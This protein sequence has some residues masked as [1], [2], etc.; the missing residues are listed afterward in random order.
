MIATLT[1]MGGV[2]VQAQVTPPTM[3]AVIYPQT[4]R[5]DVSSDY[6][7]VMVKDPYRW[8]ETDWRASNEVKDWIVAQNRISRTYLE[9]IPQRELIRKRLDD[10][11]D[12]EQV[13]TPRVINGRQFYMR[14]GPGEQQSALWV[15]EGEAGTGRKLLDPA[16]WSKDGTRALA[17]TVVA[18]QGHL[19]AYAVQDAGS[20]WRVWRVADVVTG[21]DL[22]EA[23]RWNKFTDVIWA[24]DGSGFYYTR[25][26][27]PVA[28]TEHM[29]G[30]SG[31]Q[32]YFHKLGQSQDSDRLIY[33]DQA[34]PDYLFAARMSSDGKYLLISSGYAGDGPI[35]LYK[36]LQSDGAFQPV[37]PVTDSSL[38]SLQF[39]SSLGDDI[40]FTSNIGAP[41]GRLL[42]MKPGNKPVSVIP[43]TELPLVHVTRWGNYFLAQYLRDA[44]SVVKVY[45]LKG[46]YIRD[47]R[48]P[49]LGT[50]HGFASGPDKTSVYYGF[51]SLAVPDTSYR[52]DLITGQS[53]L[54]Y[55]PLGA[56]KP[57]D[58]EVKE[59]FFTARDGKR[60]AMFLG[61]RKDVEPN[62]HTPVLLY[63]YGGF[64]WLLTP[65]FRPEQVTWMDMGGVFAMPIL[66][67]DGVYGEPWHQ[68]GM[69]ENKPAVFDAYIDAAQYLIDQGY[70][71]PG[72]LA[73]FGYSNGGLLVGA[74]ITRRP[75]L[76]A[77]AL[78]TVGVLDML[79]FP[80]F[81]NGRLWSTEYGDP[82]DPKL[83]PVLYG[84][85]PYHNIVDGRKYP[86]V[87]VGTADTDDRVAPPHSLKFAARLQAA[88][89]PGAPVL[90]SVAFNAGHGAGTSRSQVVS[91]AADRMAFTLF[92]MK[93]DL[94]ADFGTP[95]H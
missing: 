80:K 36:N 82:E 51:T 69:L 68:A 2:N 48:L 32:L 34:N 40:Y 50:A 29:A 63:G 88:A 90:L 44:T 39:V 81:T 62:G 54:V 17:G 66:P 6:Q 75:D 93:F 47:V 73:S 92:N 25:F 49:G 41:N 46:K 58:Y 53:T 52:Y 57:E 74:A 18:P 4:K 14:R 23:I 42:R 61:H 59:V 78:P 60:I 26:P 70:T 76:F 30:N 1:T 37:V 65:D 45:S 9:A 89:A 7:G 35:L 55:R 22:G 20:D 95:Q 83:F 12:I 79:R 16:Q 13:S 64:G 28:G 56:M 91:D 27:V 3:G 19:V 84:Y 11:F 72:H 10:L 38:D 21:Q 67:G 77:V 87:L 5:D 71:D 86:A 33:E 43:E 94:P 24:P 85:S 31:E 8:L 15:R